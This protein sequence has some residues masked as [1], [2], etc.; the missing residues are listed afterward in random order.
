MLRRGLGSIFFAGATA[1][2]RGG[3]SFAAAKA[4]L[5]AVAQ[6]TLLGGL[7]DDGAVAG[8]H[9]STHGRSTFSN[10]QVDRCW[11]YSCR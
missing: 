2:L 4:V 8:H 6:S 5:R 10:A 3:G 7:V 1:S 11:R 9:L